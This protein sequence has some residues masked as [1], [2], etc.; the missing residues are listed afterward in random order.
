MEWR[1]HLRALKT[2]L[3]W[4]SVPAR[5]WAVRGAKLT[6]QLT[7]S[8]SYTVEY[9]KYKYKYIYYTVYSM[10]R[11]R[12]VNFINAGGGD[13]LCTLHRAEGLYSWVTRKG[14]TWEIPVFGWRHHTMVF[15][16]QLW[17]IGLSLCV[18]TLVGME[19]KMVGLAGSI[20]E[21]SIRKLST[22]PLQS[23][24]DHWCSKE[25]RCQRGS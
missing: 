14:D 12:V 19:F 13:P 6:L 10:E 5:G 23:S 3:A 1:T 9:S 18:D 4:L 11:L 16:L 8:G 24:V 2:L 7:F 22:R 17:I 15:R 25:S 21:P 20:F